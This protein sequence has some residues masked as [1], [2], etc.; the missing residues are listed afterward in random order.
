MRVTIL[1][2]VFWFLVSFSGLSPNLTSLQ[3][4]VDQQQK[5]IL[6]VFLSR[7]QNT[8]ALAQLIHDQVGGR[9]VELELENPYPDN[10]QAIVKQVARENETGFLPTLKTKIEN[11]ERYN[12]VFVG[13]PTWG[14]RLPP[15]VKSFLNQYD[16]SGKK[17]IPFNTNGGY[18]IGNSF[19]TVK[20]LCSSST[21]LDGYSTTGGS[22]RDGIL[23]VM[24]GEKKKTTNTEVKNWLE[25]MKHLK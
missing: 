3:C 5:D 10:Y 12:I 14:M 9:L 18:G 24:E 15:P 16:L 1:L 19:E 17:V 2:V 25:K 13:F 6:I 8:K 20:K 7:T 23:F 4:E 22:E 11:I 21:V